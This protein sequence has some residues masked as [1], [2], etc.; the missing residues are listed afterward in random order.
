VA[1]LEDFAH[2]AAAFRLALNIFV[3]KPDDAPWLEG[4]RYL[5]MREWAT[6]NTYMQRSTGAR[7]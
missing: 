3:V 4:A 7:M 6:V 2:V 5:P 1:D